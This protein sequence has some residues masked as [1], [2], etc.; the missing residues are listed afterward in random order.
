MARKKKT[1]KKNCYLEATLKKP[2]AKERYAEP[3][4]KLSYFY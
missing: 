4:Q 2:L 3:K 1:T